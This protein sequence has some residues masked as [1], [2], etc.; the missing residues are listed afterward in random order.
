M[1]DRMDG[2]FSFS[3]QCE[4][5]DSLFNPL[6]WWGMN[7]ETF[8]ILSSVAKRVL[9][10]QASSSESE[11]HSSSAGKVT[12][13]ERARLKPDVIETSVIVKCNMAKDYLFKA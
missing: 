7:S 4:E 9:V 3:D 2:P 13:K 8:P 11:R 1:Y 12:R 10:V 5:E 6:K